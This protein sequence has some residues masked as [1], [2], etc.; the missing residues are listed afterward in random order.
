M[1]SI[2]AI[3]KDGIVTNLAVWDGKTK[4]KPNGGGELI[5]VKSDV[6]IGWT[7]SNNKFMPPVDEESN[8]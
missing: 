2:Y 8:E 7:Y 4:W 5:E 3:V 6:G 1:S